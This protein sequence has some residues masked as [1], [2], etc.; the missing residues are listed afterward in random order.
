MSRFCVENFLFLSTE[1]F[2]NGTLLRF[3]EL[4]VWKKIR[5]KKVGVSLYRRK[6]FVPNRKKTSWANR[7]VF[8][9][10]SVI[11][12]F[13]IIVVSRFC[14][15]ILSHSTET[16][17]RVTLV[18]QNCSGIK[19]FLDNQGIT[20][21]SNFLVS[22][23]QKSSWPNRSVF[24]RHSGIKIFWIMRYHDFVELFCLT[25][26]NYC[27]VPINDSKKLGHLNFFC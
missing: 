12:F 23:R 3:R 15:S 10:Y 6:I 24:W 5:D 22:H 4:L 26:P 21:L 20:I 14:W 8:Q 25:V 2:L 9:K 7:S 11:K 19:R 17:R 16:F 13:W 1:K 18:F 27:G